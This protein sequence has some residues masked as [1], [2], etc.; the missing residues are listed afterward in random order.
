MA[1]VI[2]EFD[3]MPLRLFDAR[4]QIQTATMDSTLFDNVG[5]SF[6]RLGALRQLGRRMQFE[7]QGTLMGDLYEIADEAGNVTEDEDDNIQIAGSVANN[8]RSQWLGLTSRVGVRGSLWRERLDAP[9]DREWITA[10]LLGVSWPRTV[11]Q[12]TV[13]AEVTLRFESAMAAWRAASLT[14]A[15][16]SATDA[17][18]TGLTVNNGGGVPVMDAVLTVTR[19]S[20]T[21]TQVNLEG[22]GINLQWTG[23]VGA[24]RALTVDAGARTVRVT[25][26]DAYSG[27]TLLSGHTARGWFPLEPGTNFFAVTVTGGNATVSLSHYNQ[28][29]A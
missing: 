1:Y 29:A 11:E 18:F 17:I 24:S 21:L 3:G 4:Q 5:G 8:L 25:G 6:D 14:T 10:R 27:W 2:T 13:R 19:T 9:A 20:G 26:V 12:R 15:Q 7:V 22:A 16:I 23:S 28:W